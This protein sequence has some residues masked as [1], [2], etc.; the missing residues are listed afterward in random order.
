MAISVAGGDLQDQVA[1][2]LILNAIEFGMEPANN[3]TAPRF[4]TSHHEDSFDP[5]PDRKQT[6]KGPGSLT[7]NDSIS[8]ETQ[9]ELAA[10]G[11]QLESKSEPIGRPAIL[12]IDLKTG[13]MQAAGDPKAARHAA[14]L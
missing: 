11:H 12:A 13:V 14:G 9:K 2:N 1:L 7:L 10:R 5:H 6:F 4:A 8:Q 3:V